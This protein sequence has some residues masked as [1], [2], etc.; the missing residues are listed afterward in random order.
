MPKGD[1]TPGGG[2]PE[3]GAPPGGRRGRRTGTLILVGVLFL[4]GI[5][6]GL[7]LGIWQV[8]RRAWK[9]DLIA[10]IDA[11]IHQDP[12]AAPGRDAW[13]RIDRDGDE[14]RRV[15]LAGRFLN[16]RE[17]LV[18]ATTD[19]GAGYW[20]V[21]PFADDRGF[22][23]LVNRG[24]V[25]PE[26]KDPASRAAGQIG[27]DTTVTGLLRITEPGGGFLRENDPAAEAWYSRDVAA[28]ARARGLAEA[29]P[30]FVD[31]AET[32]PGGYPV[33]GLTKVSFP[34]SHL[35]YALTWFTLALMSA[36]GAAYVLRSEIR[37]RRG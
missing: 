36:A 15:A 27:T 1:I 35:V 12:V 33:G 4:I 30:Y 14:Y 31:A 6:G 29:A 37:R 5:A 22:T 26:R 18:R 10:R 21:T 17:T 23:V 8:E 19:L 13:P 2:L 34:D 28:I 9:H 24:F 32:A 7:A 25:P 3:K 20:V 16:D 11:R